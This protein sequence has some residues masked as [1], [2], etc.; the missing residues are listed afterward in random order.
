MQRERGGAAHGIV[1]PG[2]EERRVQQDVDR[3]MMA[4]MYEQ[5]FRKVMGLPPVAAATVPPVKA[6]P[7]GN[8]AWR[9]PHDVFSL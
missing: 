1:S 8:P 4:R 2:P 9:G 3:A 6:V 7:N 5:T